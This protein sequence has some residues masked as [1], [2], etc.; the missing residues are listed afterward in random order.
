MLDAALSWAARGFRVFPLAEGT[1]DKP[2]CKFTQEAS[3]D[4]ALIRA[5]WSDPM[6]GAIRNHNI[7]VLTTGMVVVDIDVKDGKPGFESWA[8][9]DGRFDTL[10]VLT[11]SG[12]VQLYYSGPDSAGRQ[13]KYGLGEGI[14][15]RSHGN[16]VVAPGSFT[17]AAPN[18][19]EGPYTLLLD[20]PV[21][22]VPAAVAVRLKPPL[23]RDNAASYTLDE[24]PGLVARAIA[25]L[26][27][28]QAPAAVEGENGDDTTYRVAC[29]LRDL[30]VS[31]QAA[32]A[33]LLTHWNDRCDP[34]WEPDDLN[35][36]VEN[37]YNYAT[38]ALGQMSP[39]TH[40]ADLQI[41][42]VPAPAPVDTQSVFRFGN[43]LDPVVIPPRP[44]L[45]T[46][47]LL[48]GQITMLVGPGSVGKSVLAL[49][50]AAHLAM[51]QPF[52]D[53]KPKYGAARSIVYDEED[54]VAEM[55]RR[56]W[57]ICHEYNFDF[58][59]VRNEI[60]LVSRNELAFRLTTNDP[61]SMNAAHVQ[62]LVDAAKD[63]RVGLVALGPFVSIHSTAEDDNV[64]M[65]FVMG[66][67]REIAEATNVAI[68]I[69]HHVS[70]PNGAAS[71]AGDANTSRGASAIVNAARFAFT[72][73]TPTEQDC[74][75][76][77]IK[78]DERYDFVAMSDAKMNYAKAM[79]RAN[80]LVK[81]SVK[82]ANTDEVGVLLPHDME[83]TALVTQTMWATTIAAGMKGAA[84]GSCTLSDAANYLRAA[85]PLAG[86]LPV[87]TLRARVMTALSDGVTTEHGRV[88]VLGEVKGGKLEANVVLE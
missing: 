75:L 61:P 16:Y 70:K 48:R 2:L 35:V 11:P 62:A 69:G 81:R 31:E 8:R 58:D 25:F 23:T 65:A 28:D 37:A 30:G 18:A 33:L 82:L 22:P 83:H 63:P 60:A 79:A 85:D 86:K 87:A 38:G 4:A 26:Q 6:T 34:P 12:G 13:G 3:S 64:K 46:R 53:Y 14:D 54:D 32:F 43:A 40:F 24:T 68:M 45:M 74:D 17:V 42:P 49:T 15:L 1:K 51:G 56:L 5:W 77:G 9:L 55:S 36:K 76:Y 84:T 27:S 66:V 41:P 39:E 57:A 67:A 52:L 44:W 73:S 50:I 88:R 47:M 20:L 10:A 59:F 29:R 19:K 72:L 78:K 21:V 71:R 80:W 7:G